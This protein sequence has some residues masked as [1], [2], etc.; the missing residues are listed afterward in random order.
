ML[1]FLI[2][3]QIIRNAKLIFA[4]QLKIK[5]INLK[6][7]QPVMQHYKNAEEMQLYISF[8]SSRF[9]AAKSLQ[10]FFTTCS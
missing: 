7:N 5:E 9:T 2:I 8:S 3:A 4:K 1:F 6:S 10:C